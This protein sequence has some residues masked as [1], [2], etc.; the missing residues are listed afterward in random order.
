MFWRKQDF[1]YRDGE[2]GQEVH[3]GRLRKWLVRTLTLGALVGFF[4]R[5]DWVVGELP[6][7]LREFDGRELVKSLTAGRT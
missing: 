5:R 1:V 7:R 2:S 3:P 6:R 4:I